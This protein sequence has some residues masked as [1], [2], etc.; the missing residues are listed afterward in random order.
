LLEN[1]LSS[2]RDNSPLQAA[3]PI[4]VRANAAARGT[5]ERNHWTIQAIATHTHT[6]YK[7]LS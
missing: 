4:V 5:G 3:T 2:N 6:Q 1:G 7:A